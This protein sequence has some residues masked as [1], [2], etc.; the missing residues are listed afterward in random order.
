MEQQ[1]A[2]LRKRF[3]VA[4][5]A[6]SMSKIVSISS[7]AGAACS[8]ALLLAAVSG[9]GKK[10][11]LIYPDMLV[12]ASP[13]AVVVEQAGKSFKLSMELPSK[14]RAGKRIKALGAVKVERMETDAADADCKKCPA[15]FML[16]KTIDLEFPA[17]A[18]LSGSRL[19]VVDADLLADK[20]YLYRVTAVLKEGG[21]GQPS[22]PVAARLH[23]VPQKP[24]IKGAGQ[25]GSVRI[26]AEAAVTE[27]ELVEIQLFKSIKGDSSP[28]VPGFRLP[29]GK[30]EMEDQEVVHGRQYLY[31][32][33]AVVR[34]PDKVLVQSELSDPVELGSTE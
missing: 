26:I 34:M 8:F 20:R 1:E 3:A 2:G 22:A 24:V 23:P 18:E 12:P 4:G 17:P 30:L 21:D 31:Q 10:A 11:P 6:N 13:S 28:A 9:C 32:G 7:R 25:I 27:G 16:Y 5:K 14:N 29:A 33:R 15:D 19:S